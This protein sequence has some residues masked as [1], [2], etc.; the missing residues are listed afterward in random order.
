MARKNRLI[1]LPPTMD[2][3]KGELAKQPE[4][5]PLKPDKRSLRSAGR[6]FQFNI[7]VSENFREQYETVR[8]RDRL[9][10]RW[11]WAAVAMKAYNALPKDE[12]DRLISEVMAEDPAMQQYPSRR[13]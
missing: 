7:Q 4:A 11:Q 6:S 9:L 3:T 2:E 12:R 10:N 5:A 8:K 13:V 1:E